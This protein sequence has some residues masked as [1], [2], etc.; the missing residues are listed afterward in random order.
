MKTFQEASVF[1]HMFWL[2]VLGDHARFILDSLAV[3]EKEDI[4]KATE[5][6]QAFDTLLKKATEQNDM[7]TLTLE[8][9]AY[10][11]QFRVFK[12]S[13]IK[14]HLVG[15]IKIQLPPTFINHMVNELD[16]YMLVL[17]YLK[18][19]EVPPIFHELHHHL[20]WLLDAAGHAGAISD[21]LD[22]VE[23]RLK[24]KSDVFTKHFEQFYLK[25]IELSGFLR[26]NVNSFPALTRMNKEVTLEI[27]M[28]RMFLDEIEELEFS[29]E[30]L[31]TFSV[32][33]ADHMLREECYYLTKVAEATDAGDPNCDPTHPR[34][35]G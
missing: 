33:M 27:E 1:E 21:N 11:K 10:V 12:L 24:E 30:M 20:L 25:A 29:N 32:L 7:Y 23:K 9:E 8:A 28:F 31:S 6:K 5:F 17:K 18:K 14:R 35:E 2:Q 22:A 3:S 16:E 13:L 19:N 15:K 26:A 4:K 34:I